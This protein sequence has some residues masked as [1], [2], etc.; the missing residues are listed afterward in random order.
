MTT[1]LFFKFSNKNLK[2]I[3]QIVRTIKIISLVK[4]RNRTKINLVIIAKIKQFN[5]F[6]LIK[7][8]INKKYFIYKKKGYYIKEYLFLAQKKLEKLAKK[9]KCA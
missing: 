9:A 4:C 6:Y 1:V 7:P 2:K 5:K 8:K 3:K